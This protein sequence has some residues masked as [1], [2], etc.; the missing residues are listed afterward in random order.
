MEYD[1]IQRIALGF[2]LE[3]ETWPVFM[4]WCRKYVNTDACREWLRS[5]PDINDVR[6]MYVDHLK[7]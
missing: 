2:V 5:E 1:D 4:E 7:G 3:T 6:G